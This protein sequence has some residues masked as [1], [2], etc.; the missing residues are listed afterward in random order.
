MKGVKRYTLQ[1]ERSTLK[2]DLKLSL[3]FSRQTRSISEA[4]DTRIR[5]P[6]DLGIMHRFFFLTGITGVR[7]N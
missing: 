4:V 5:E 6:L 1:K 7:N 3:E 2:F